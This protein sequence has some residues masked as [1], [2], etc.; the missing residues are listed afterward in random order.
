MK[1]KLGFLLP[2]ALLALPAFADD[3]DDAQSVCAPH[4]HAS[5]AI[6]FAN[7]PGDLMYDPGWEHCAK[8]YNAWAKRKAANDALDETK[9]PALAKS[10]AIAKGLQ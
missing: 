1:M 10:R 3:L 9:N 7:R 8:I 4:L 5:S 6:S 2:F